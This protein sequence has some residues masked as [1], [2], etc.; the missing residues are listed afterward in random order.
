MSVSVS[1][2]RCVAT[3]RHPSVFSSSQAPVLS[4]PQPESARA[5]SSRRRSAAR[6]TASCSCGRSRSARSSNIVLNE[7]IARWQLATGKN[8][9]RRVGRVSAGVGEMYFGGLSRD[10]DG[11]RHRGADQ[12]DRS[13]HQQSHAAGGLRSRGAASSTACSGSSSCCWADTAASR[14]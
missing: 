14:R 9:A 10:L 6:A 7:G 1:R 8:R 13:R 5:T 4:S 3:G 11:G 12:C 2:C